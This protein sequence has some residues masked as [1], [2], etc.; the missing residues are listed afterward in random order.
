[1]V[2]NTGLDQC[3]AG[4]SIVTAVD[5]D[6]DALVGSFEI[7]GVGVISADVDALANKVRGISRVSIG[8]KPVGECEGRSIVGGG[9]IWNSDKA[10][11][12]IEFEGASAD[13]ASGLPNC[14][15]GKRAAIARARAVRRRDA[16]D[17]V[18]LEPEHARWVWPIGGSW[19]GVDDH[20]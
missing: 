18:E 11:C 17:I 4:E 20:V 10:V 7:G 2:P 19:A 8:T 13:T 3:S 16:R 15:A 1:M 9:S 5:V 12:A 6:I 14:A